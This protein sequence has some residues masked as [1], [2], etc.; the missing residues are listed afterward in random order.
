[1]KI[2]FINYQAL[3]LPPVKGGAVEYLVDSYLKYNETN[4]LHDITL[5]SIFDNDAK[6]KSKEYKHTKFK[7]IKIKGIFDKFDRIIRHILNK[8]TK[9]YVGNTYISKV[10]RN[11]KD[12]NKY[13]AIIIENAP[14]FALKIRKKFKNTLILHLH[15]DYLNKNT[16]NARKILGCYDYVYTIS[17][18]LGSLV[19]TIDKTDKV[20]TLYNGVNLNKFSKDE[21]LKKVMKEKYFIKD[22]DFVYMYCGRLTKDKGAYELCKAFSQIDDSNIKLIIAGG[23]GYSTNTPNETLLK[24]KDLEDERIILTGFVPYEE[25][26]GLYQLA[27]VGVVPSICQDAFNLTVIEFASNSIPLI[28]SDQGAM[29]E[30]VNKDSCVI[31]KYNEN[32]VDNLKK[33]LLYMK[34]ADIKKMG[35]EAK[36][37]SQN[38]SIE[39]YCERYNYLLN[40]I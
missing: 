5:Y 2:L 23:T 25:I 17:D 36:K 7:F 35:E 8:Y 39:K 12:F 29:K 27:D 10:I 19:K 28:I 14:E 6:I 24:I 20:H 16:K 26:N 15:N 18:T 3:P 11:E 34:E 22:D 13:D 4:H 30:L 40:N 1:M 32:Y 37:I 21:N 31:A 33:C 9:V 38:F